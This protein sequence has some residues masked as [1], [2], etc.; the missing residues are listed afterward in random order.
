MPINGVFDLDENDT[1]YVRFYQW[2]GSSG[3]TDIVANQSYAWFEGY[4][5]G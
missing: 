1:A 2:T 3:V 4:L 5:L